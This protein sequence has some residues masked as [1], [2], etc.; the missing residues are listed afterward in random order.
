MYI[1]VCLPIF[2]AIVDDM[3]K[4]HLTAILKED[5]KTS[6]KN[7]DKTQNLFNYIN[8]KRA[9]DRSVL[10]KYTFSILW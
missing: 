1:Y 6:L 8:Y 2:M 9:E 5:I 3:L 7:T 4:R 10:N